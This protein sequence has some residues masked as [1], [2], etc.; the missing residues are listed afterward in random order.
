[1]PQFPGRNIHATHFLQHYCGQPRNRPSHY[2]K[3][4]HCFHL[5][6]FF[7]LVAQFHRSTPADLRALL[8]SRTIRTRHIEKGPALVWS[9]QPICALSRPA[10]FYRRRST[11]I[12]LA[13]KRGA[14]VCTSLA[15]SPLETFPFV[16]KLARSGFGLAA[17]RSPSF[18]LV[19]RT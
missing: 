19:R 5:C 2:C 17:V 12:E 16:I 6:T 10:R 9:V 11:T 8:D 7:S 14:V 3:F 4:V 18:Y 15:A 13:T 1:V